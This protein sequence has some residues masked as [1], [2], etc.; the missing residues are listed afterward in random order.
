[1]IETTLHPIQG[2]PSLKE[3]D[4]AVEELRPF[5]FQTP[6]NLADLLQDLYQT[7]GTQLL[8][9]TIT[10]Q[11]VINLNGYS[12]H[13][14]LANNTLIGSQ[15]FAPLTNGEF[16]VQRQIFTD[17]GPINR[18]ELFSCDGLYMRSETYASLSIQTIEVLQMEPLCPILSHLYNI[19]CY[20]Y[21]QAK[22]GTSNSKRIF[23]IEQIL[24][25]RYLLG[26]ENLSACYGYRDPAIKQFF[27]EIL[28]IEKDPVLSWEERHVIYDKKKS[29]IKKII[30]TKKRIH[31]LSWPKYNF[32]VTAHK[33]Q[34]TFE[35]LTLRPKSNLKGLSYRYTI[36]VLIWFFKTVKDNLG[37]SIALAIYG[38]FTFY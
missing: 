18:Y 3:L 14:Y 8:T 2:L 10:T 12:G 33:I 32:A 11:K 5:L 15:Y 31:R 35:R 21:A 16:V 26:S 36:G 27:S 25:Q 9:D 34:N 13:Q 4:P 37:Y 1:M 29:N 6:T 38:P 23:T 20:E 19:L 28:E 17:Q 30:A 22:L 24:R 7:G